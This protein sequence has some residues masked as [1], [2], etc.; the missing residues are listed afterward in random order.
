[1]AGSFL[2]MGCNK[3]LPD[4]VPIPRPADGTSPTLG[5]LLDAP[6]YSILKSAV[7][8]AGLMAN[9]SNP[10]NR[11]TI[12]APDNAA[13]IASG[14]PQAAIDALPVA[15]VTGIVS[16]HVVPQLVNAA[17]IPTTFPNLQYPSIL[18]PAPSVSALLRLTTFPSKRGANV[19]VNN[20]PVIAAEQIAVN[21]IIHKVARVV[22][23]PTMDLWANI[24]TNTQLT[25]LKAT[26]SRA[27][28]GAKVGAR[29]QDALNTAVN[30]SAIASNLTVFAPSDDAMKLFLTGALVQAFVAA[31]F[32][33]LQAQGAATS[34]VTAFGSQIISN[35]ASIP[36]VTGFPPMLGAR[37]AAVITPTLAKGIAVYHIVGAQSG[38]FSPPGIRLFSVNLPT[39]ATSIKTLLNS[40]VAVH[41]GL[42]VMATFG[43]AGVTAATV[44]GAANAT[45]SNVQIN[46]LPGGTSDQHF[47]NGVLHVIDQV[48]L[49]Q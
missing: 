38:T 9:L 6:E 8:K 23:P 4:A 41:P 30:P 12:F 14:V 17:S 37:L 32:P 21:G 39:S 46:P 19:W 31:G 5:T 27:D 13:F 26:I 29:L 35:P 24:N 3:A 44:K 28:S 22:A 45:A 42:S 15:Q 36:D 16:Y 1:M 10:A 11:F 40:A 34:L 33:L 20:I 43:P 18:N 47:V 48:L 49:P 2:M 7:N 25:Y